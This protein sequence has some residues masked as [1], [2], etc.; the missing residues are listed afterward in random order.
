MGVKEIAVSFL[1]VM[2]GKF[3]QKIIFYFQGKE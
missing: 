3:Y 2:I 1:G